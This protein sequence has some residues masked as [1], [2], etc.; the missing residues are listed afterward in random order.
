MSESGTLRI[1]TRMT[2]GATVADVKLMRAAVSDKVRV[3]ASGGIRTLDMVLACR[4]AGAAR[5]GV[6]AT[7]KI[8]EEAKKRLE[9]GTLSD[10]PLNPV[11]NAAGGAY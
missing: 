7:V 5:C 10:Q 2:A 4:N 11:E 6:S 8:M 3:K 1:H 9:E